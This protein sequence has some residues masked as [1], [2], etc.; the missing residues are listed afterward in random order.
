MPAPRP[1]A[2]VTGAARGI[3][4]GISYALAGSG[5]D[6]VVND[7]AETE[8]V[9]VT[10][11]GIRERGGK[12]A[13]IAADVTRIDGHDALVGQA[14]AA[15]GRLD[16]LVNNA[17]VGVLSRGDL[18]D[19]SVESYDR[20][21]NVNLRGSFF[22]TQRVARRMLE[23]PHPDARRPAPSSP[24]PRSTPKSHRLAVANTA[25]PRPGHR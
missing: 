5:F 4:R 19:V 18:L 11:A 7:L 21:L 3:G 23:D 6:V 12:A 20:C 24:S 22:L 9:A 2:L 1:V 8:D 14:F 16:C 25:S 15:F 13:F 10:L 17:G